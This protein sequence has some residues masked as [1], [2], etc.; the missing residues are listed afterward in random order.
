[1]FSLL[2]CSTDFPSNRSYQ[3][4]RYGARKDIVSVDSFMVHIVGSLHLQPHSQ[5]TS[6][7]YH[8]VS[9]LIRQ[10][11]SAAVDSSFLKGTTRSS[12]PLIHSASFPFGHSKTMVKNP[13]TMCCTFTCQPSDHSFFPTTTAQFLFDLSFTRQVPV[14]PRRPRDAQRATTA[15]RSRQHERYIVVNGR[16]PFNLSCFVTRPLPT[17]S[18]SSFMPSYIFPPEATMCLPI[19]SPSSTTI[20]RITSKRFHG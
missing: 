19:A 17:P 18:I 5:F 14:V 9:I 7:F 1:M 16:C 13:N 8:L 15:N 3:W 11:D 4:T 2:S 12:P 10:R 20:S 6:G